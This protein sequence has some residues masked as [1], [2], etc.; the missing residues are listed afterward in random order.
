MRMKEET[1]EITENI[2]DDRCNFVAKGRIDT[3]SSNILL[4]NLEKALKR[5]HKKIIL[6]M[7]Q[8]EFLSSVGIRVILQIYK[9]AIK[10]GS[11]FNI[12]SPSEI[13]RNVLGMVAL[14]QLIAK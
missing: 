1:F 2:E 3:N 13:V 5:D 6:N 10:A 9:Q 14:N 4:F 11:K 8:V 12:E 7:A